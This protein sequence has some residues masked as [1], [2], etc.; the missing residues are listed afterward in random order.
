MLDFRK[1]FAT[2]AAMLPPTVIVIPNSPNISS[3]RQQEQT[4]NLGE[5]HISGTLTS[6]RMALNIFLKKMKQKKILTFFVGIWNLN[7]FTKKRFEISLQL[8]RGSRVCFSKFAFRSSQGNTR[9]RC[10]KHNFAFYLMHHIYQPTGFT[11]IQHKELSRTSVPSVPTLYLCLFCGRFF[12]SLKHQDE[13]TT[14][15]FCM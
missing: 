9:C 2:Q 12:L 13:L 6:V 11:H 7:I 5:T 8:F 3:F 14:S 15:S 4:N 1:S 10:Q